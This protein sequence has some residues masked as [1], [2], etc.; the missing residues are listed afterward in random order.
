MGPV[1]LNGI[2]LSS[3]TPVCEVG[4]EDWDIRETGD[5]AAAI[6]SVL[7][8]DVRVC[9]TREVR[10]V[11]GV[12]NVAEG[13]GVGLAMCSSCGRDGSGAAAGVK[14]VWAGV[15]ECVSGGRVT[16]GLGEDWACICCGS[17][18]VAVT[19]GLMGIEAVGF[20]AEAWLACIG[21]G[22][23]GSGTDGVNLVEL[24][25]AM[26]FAA[27]VLSVFVVGGGAG[28]GPGVRD[29]RGPGALSHGNRS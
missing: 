9:R 17:A 11:G 8:A 16:S 13:S 10:V 21:G 7:S 24:V 6:G 5:C 28:V 3:E 23:A 1:M 20:C 14:G 4:A 15:E 22:G 25:G 26:G 12:W 18:I 2:R 29:C 27:G 19:S